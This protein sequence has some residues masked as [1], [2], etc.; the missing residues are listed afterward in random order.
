MHI[1]MQ[2]GQDVLMIEE[3]LVDGASILDTS[4]SHG[5]LARTKWCL[6]FLQNLSL[7]LLLKPWLRWFGSK[8]YSQSY[9][10][11]YHTLLWSCDLLWQLV[12]L[13]EILSY[14]HKLNMWKLVF[15][16]LERRL[17]LERSQYIICLAKNK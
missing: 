12:I 6:Y 9:M 17:C 5:N 2:I 13:P 7:G 4:S 15:S 3:V 14:I 1:Q 11:L 16:L 10:C 8:D